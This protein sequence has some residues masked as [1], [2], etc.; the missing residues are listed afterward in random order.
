MVYLLYPFTLKNFIT[1]NEEI[2]LSYSGGLKGLITIILLLL[3]EQNINTFNNPY[4][5]QQVISFLILAILSTTI[6]NGISCSYLVK[7]LLPKLSSSSQITLLSTISNLE[8]KIY[9][10]KN[11][12]QQLDYF[13]ELNDIEQL[14]I[15]EECLFYIEKLKI[16]LTKHIAS[17]TKIVSSS[18]ESKMIEQ[19][20]NSELIQLKESENISLI[21]HNLTVANIIHHN[22]NIILEP[23]KYDIRRRL[24]RAIRASHWKQL[25][26]YWISR[27]TAILLFELAKYS[28][29]FNSIDDYYR[30]IESNIIQN[31]LPS[32]IYKILPSGIANYYH[33]KYLY[34]LIESIICLLNALIMQS[35]SP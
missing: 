11:R 1:K 19:R 32:Y 21:K 24:L 6:I 27:K 35:L 25:N 7:Y 18:L 31:D 29:D 26:H 15:G 4:K 2:I 3:V 9:K 28:S 30:L 34:F 12:L 8:L 17:K 13:N 14:C 22:N 20:I 23:F 16:K 10:E 33:K 5:I